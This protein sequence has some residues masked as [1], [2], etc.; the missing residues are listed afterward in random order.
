MKLLKIGRAA[1][2]DIVLNN[3]SVSQEH[4]HLIIENTG[5]ITIKD[6][7]STNGTYV[8]GRRINEAELNQL[9][10][11][12]I[13][14]ITLDWKAYINKP[15]TVGK[16]VKTI[17]IGRASSND[18][19]ISQEDV[20]SFH[21]KIFKTSDGKIYLQD[22][23]S[24][25]GTYVN[26]QKIKQKQ[27]VAGDKITLA[28]SFP[29]VWEHIFDKG[30]TIINPQPQQI[31]A[32]PEQTKKSH[33]LPIVIGTIALIIVCGAIFFK[34]LKTAIFP[35]DVNEKYK[36]SVVLVYHSYVYE[37][38][39]NGSPLM[40]NGKPLLITSNEDGDLA[41]YPS[42]CPNPIAI[43][44]TG[45]FVSNYGQIITNR[46]VAQPW[47]YE[48]HGEKKEKVLS[49][50]KELL[51]NYYNS[52][53]TNIGDV[54]KIMEK[55]NNTTVNGRTI[56]LG[57]VLND[58]YV[59]STNDLIPCISSKVSP[60][61]KIDVALIQ[62]KSKTLPDKVK[63]FIDLNQAVTDESKLK[64]GTELYM[65]GY[66]AGFTLANT[67]KGIMAN[68]QKGQISRE[69]DGI[70]FGHNIPTIGGA[71]G[72]PIFNSAGNLV[73]INYQGMTNTQGFNMAIIAKHIVELSK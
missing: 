66:P 61:S 26:G 70:D 37:V 52:L 18:M 20:S 72:S 62:T 19:V 30:R 13:A 54:E 59:N 46:H 16:I 35:V 71:S 51:R 4:A 60:N 34:P 48:E 27:L 58:S 32:K 65:I 1:T 64:N 28:N 14:N 47:D 21:A 8:N 2:N 12:S 41:F 49:T 23:D 33:T 67:K 50:V 36:N 44:G 24:T 63:N 25:N 55:L 57:I 5:K 3:P 38:L 15:E 45:F 7:N 11:I 53:A 31:P 56:E 9:D 6:L 68:F 40:I 43:T 39:E 29:F 69:S 17:N 73:G 22:N 10:T 42:K